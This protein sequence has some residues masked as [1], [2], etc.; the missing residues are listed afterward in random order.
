MKA[1]A[2]LGKRLTIT[3]ELLCGDAVTPTIPRA[4]P[5]SVGDLLTIRSPTALDFKW[6]SVGLRRKKSLYGCNQHREQ[7]VTLASNP[8]STPSGAQR[9][10]KPHLRAFGTYRRIRRRARAY[11]I[12]SHGDNHQIEIY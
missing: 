1:I 7:H 5:T 10:A 12:A 8:R 2:S 9:V 3:P 6:G 11:R 4:T